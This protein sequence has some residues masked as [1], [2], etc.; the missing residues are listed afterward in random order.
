M[1][2]FILKMLNNSCYKQLSGKPYN[3]K[4]DIYSLG[5]I[6]F[7]LLVPFNT[8]MERMH[9]LTDLRHKKFP[10]DFQRDRKEEVNQ[11]YVLKKSNV[12]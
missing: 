12:S 7:E 6:L 5:L 8:Q 10:T 9:I 1:V 2:T 11:I 3:Y 4:V